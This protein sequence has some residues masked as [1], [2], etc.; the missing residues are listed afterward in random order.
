MIL[1]KGILLFLLFGSTTSSLSASVQIVAASTLISGLYPLSATYDDN[2][3]LFLIYQKTDKRT[4]IIN[5]LNA[6]AQYLQADSQYEIWLLSYGG[7]LSCEKEA[8][9]RASKAKKYIVGRSIKPSRVTI[10]DAGYH[11]EWVVEIWLV[12]HG[13]PGPSPHPSINPKDVKI[14]RCRKKKRYISSKGKKA[15]R[16][17]NFPFNKPNH[18]PRL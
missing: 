1:Y 3:H 13:T 14:L 16:Y 17:S 8:K 9:D 11:E 5:K 4:D 10:V 18:P 6:V 12:I 15:E 7:K 2:F